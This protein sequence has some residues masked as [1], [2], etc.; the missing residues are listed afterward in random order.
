MEGN[1][2]LF[3]G[4][5]LDIDDVETMAESVGLE[6]EDLLLLNTHVSLPSEELSAPPGRPGRKKTTRD[7]AL[8]AHKWRLRGMTWKEIFD[9]WKRLYPNDDR[10][11]NAEQIR[12]AHRR[13]FGD[14]AR[15]GY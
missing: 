14:K 3:E 9:D 4:L 13:Y 5:G 7:I 11:K 8:F 15:K 6:A 12:E 10:V 2:R 1:L